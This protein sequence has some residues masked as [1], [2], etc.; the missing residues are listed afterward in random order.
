[1]RAR[2]KRSMISRWPFLSH[3]VRIATALIVATPLMVAAGC[4]IGSQVASPASDPH[5]FV[6]RHAL[7]VHPH[8]LQSSPPALFVEFPIP[9]ASSQ[10]EGLAVGP[11]SLVYFTEFTGNKIG[12][13]T[14][15]G[16]ITEFP[17]PTAAS[18]PSYI[19]SAGTAALWF[20]ESNA[21]QLGEIGVNG[22]ISEFPVPTAASGL[23]AI[24]FTQAN[25]GM[26]FTESA[27]NKIG[28]IAIQTKNITEYQLPTAGSRPG[29]IIAGPQGGMFFTEL[30][31]AR[32]GK[33]TKA[34]LITEYPIPA[35]AQYIDKASDGNLYF[36]MPTRQSLGEMTAGGVYV[37]EFP[38]GLS[39]SLPWGLTGGTQHIDIWYL[40]RSANAVMSF[41]TFDHTLAVFTATTPASDPFAIQ[42]ARDENLWF[43]ERAANIIGVYVR[44]RM[45]VTP[46]S[47]T[48]STVGQQQS[49]SVVERKYTLTF[50]TTG[51]PLKIATVSP[52]P[53]T[54][55]TITAQ[56]AGSCTISVRDK[57]ANTS[58]VTVTVN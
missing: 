18:G 58:N 20:V 48:F 37:T 25:T 40:D 51:C 17:I 56:G 50:T 41:N 16:A 27:A 2:L 29:G 43:T 21:N 8:V 3:T 19:A 5:A 23:T 34:G 14:Q 55:F 9:T 1:M 22:A 47:L 38:T 33:I 49:F 57:F 28:T 4:G 31:A 45:T 26:W 35:P 46:N 52:G 13:I 15:T 44:L 11:D 32:I 12:R 24:A 36:T 6:Q 30:G 53:A 39:P 42:M 7:D 54:T 10:P